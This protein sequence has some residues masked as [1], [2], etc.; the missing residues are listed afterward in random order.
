MSGSFEGYRSVWR[1]T[2][3]PKRV[4]LTGLGLVVWGSGLISGQ[5]QEPA[6]KPAKQPQAV[7]VTEAIPPLPEIPDEPKTVDPATTMPAK[8]AKRATQDFS[9]SSLREVVDWLAKQDLVVLLDKNAL[10]SVGISPAEPVS[11][12]LNDAP[13]YL[14]LQRLKSLDLA[15][16]YEDDILHITSWEVADERQTTLPYNVGDLLDAGYKLDQLQETVT[17]TVAPTTW[18]DVGG[19]GVLS[20]LGDV[21]FIRQSD[22][23]QREVQGL[24]TALRKHGRQTYINDPPQHLVLREKLNENVSVEF[25]DTPLETAIAQ[26]AAQA[27]ADIRLDLP[28]LR[29]ARIREREPVTLKLTDRKLETVL[30]ALLLDLDLTW[31]LR[32]GVLWITDTGD[33]EGLIKT[34]VYDVRDLCRD[35]DESAALI[36]AVL[37][38]TEPISWDVVGGPGTISPV[39]PGTIVV[40]HQ[41]SVHRELLELLE[42]YRTALRASK[43]RDRDA[44]DPNE[45][46]TTYYRMH[47]NVARDLAKLLPQLVEPETWKS[48]AHPDSPGT[49]TLVASAPDTTSAAFEDGDNKTPASELVIARS[50]LIIRQTRGT[51]QKIA[52][53][54]R[55]VQSGDAT[56]SLEGGGMG[57]MGGG[58]MGGMGGFGGGFFSVPAELRK[59]H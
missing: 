57:G 8:L 30:Q 20:S 49:V 1:R 55:R 6:E 40:S 3:L 23:L 53:A 28:S 26:L 37:S 59:A 17:N 41:E 39:K 36:D 21:I 27:K 43:P 13:I 15:W 38:Q 35:K 16:F 2:F 45:V 29:E 54:I 19:P 9:D 50:V 46:L 44:E 11:D 51:H 56:I 58:G 10:S 34:A 33:A 22:E 24:L 31:M 18:E 5:A 52:E 4:L 12:R 7:E 14:L 32:D 25:I 47:E 48:E 42:T